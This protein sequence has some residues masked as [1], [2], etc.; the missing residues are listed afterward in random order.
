VLEAMAMAVEK[1]HTVII[2]LSQKYKDSPNCR[3]EAEYTFRLRKK[4][5][6]LRLQTGYYPDG[7]LGILVGSKLV[8]DVSQQT[9][10]EDSIK[11]LIKELSQ[12]AEESGTVTAPTVTKSKSVKCDI[13]KLF[14]NFKW[15]KIYFYS[16]Y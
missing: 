2:C 12:G 1:A 10:Y 6:P 8:F 9:K 14:L 16:N 5:I 4:V 13:K 11:H 7:W 3:T 15:I